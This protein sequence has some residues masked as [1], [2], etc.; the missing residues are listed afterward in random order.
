MRI[1]A[2]KSW[3]KRLQSCTLRLVDV[4]LS[5]R[6]NKQVIM[7]CWLVQLGINN[8]RDV[9]KFCQIGLARRLVQ[10][11]GKICKHQLVLLIPNCNSPTQWNITNC[12]MRPD[13]SHFITLLFLTPDNFTHQRDNAG[14]M[15]HLFTIYSASFVK[16]V[17]FKFFLFFNSWV[18]IIIILKIKYIVQYVSQL[19]V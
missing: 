1:I 19:F 7:R 13:T 16:Q 17:L 18:C 8:T 4:I 14:L 15:S 12:A 6:N 2:Y 3:I 11:V 9:C 5:L 10:F